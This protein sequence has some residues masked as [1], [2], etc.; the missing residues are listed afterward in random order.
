M[1]QNVL[2]VHLLLYLL[3]FV[4][5]YQAIMEHCVNYVKLT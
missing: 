3:L 1:I 5:V 4:N 2:I